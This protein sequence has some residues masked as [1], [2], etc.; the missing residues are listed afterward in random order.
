MKPN[1]LQEVPGIS[2]KKP[3]LFPEEKLHTGE[4]TPWWIGFASGSAH[5]QEVLYLSLS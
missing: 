2:L 4:D 3:P 1:R 5:L